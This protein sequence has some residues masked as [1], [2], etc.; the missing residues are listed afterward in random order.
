M[1]KLVFRYGSMNS[2]KSANLIMQ[3]YSYTNDGKDILVFK[4]EVDTRSS[5]VTSR[6]LNTSIDADY[7]VGKEDYGSMTNIALEMM[8]RAIYIDE[9]HFLDSKQIEELAKI[10]D[11]I[12][13]T[14]HGFGLMTDFKGEL[15][16]GSKR[17][18]ELADV[19][20]RIRSEC[21]KCSNEGIMNARYIDGEIQT[22]GETVMIGA[23]EKYRVLCR[24]CYMSELDKKKRG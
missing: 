5:A 22:H 6:A 9:V 8:P 18:V 3:H 4:P 10:V 11:K 12:G 17:L 21:T 14:V 7:V 24:K 2:A 19:V 16:S 13:V 23:E 1:A 15:F 20:E